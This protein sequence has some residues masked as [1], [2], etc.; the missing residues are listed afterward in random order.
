MDIQIN[1]VQFAVEFYKPGNEIPCG[2]GEYPFDDNCL[3]DESVYNEEDCIKLADKDTKPG[4]M[5][6]AGH[7]YVVIKPFTIIRPIAYLGNHPVFISAMQMEV[8]NM[9]VHDVFQDWIKDIIELA[10]PK[11]DPESEDESLILDVNSRYADS[12]LPVS[13]SIA[14]VWE[15]RYTEAYCYNAGI[16]EGESEWDLL[17]AVDLMTIGKMATKVE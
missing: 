12:R 10:T 13:I 15:W 5:Y 2:E 3:F 4:N 1:L 6:P 8:E 14:T 17:G 11:E 7:L 16:Y 9:T